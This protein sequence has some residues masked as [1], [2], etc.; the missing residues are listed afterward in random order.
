MEYYV[1]DKP[2][3]RGEL[4]LRGN[5]MFTEYYKSP[6]ETANAITE[7]GWFRTGMCA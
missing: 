5:T 3:P 2:Y 7:D 1:D 6:E 4:L